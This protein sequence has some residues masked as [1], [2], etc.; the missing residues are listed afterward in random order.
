VRGQPHRII[1]QRP[2][3]PHPAGP[4]GLGQPP[5]LRLHVPGRPLVFGLPLLLHHPKA[6]PL[7]GHPGPGLAQHPDRHQPLQPTPGR[8]GERVMMLRLHTG[9]LTRPG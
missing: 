9:S 1:D 6:G 7:G 2:P 4:L 5:R 3:L 8:L